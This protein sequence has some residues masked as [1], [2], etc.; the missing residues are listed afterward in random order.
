[1]PLATLHEAGTDGAP[2]ARGRRRPSRAER[3]LAARMRRRDRTV[4]AELYA[5]HGRATFGF[6]VSALGDRAAAEDVQQQVFLE[7][8]QRGATYDPQQASPATWLM[9]IARS[10]A[11]DHL[12]R[13]V[14]EPRDPA[15]A[16]TLADR[17][18][19][20]A[21]DELHDRWWL[22]AVLSELPD[23]ESEP[24]RLRFGH[25]LTQAE[26]AQALG[27]PLGTVKTRMARALD[28][29]RVVLADEHGSPARHAPAVVARGRS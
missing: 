23:D 15:V 14:P 9:M 1:M 18:A 5:A 17:S 21:L 20:G 3:R 29:L 4:L 6:L 24:L 25:G 26:I 13:R 28:R 7:A 27:L 11:I 2:A 19:G 8:W 10:R 16:A 12:R 22:A